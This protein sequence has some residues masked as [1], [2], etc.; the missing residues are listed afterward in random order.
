MV[1]SRKASESIMI[2][3]NIEIIVSEISGDSCRIAINA[4]REIPVMRRELLETRRL[5]REAGS[6]PKRE[7]LQKLKDLLK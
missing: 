7:A 3:D 5:N 2:G 4:P 6:I 1:I